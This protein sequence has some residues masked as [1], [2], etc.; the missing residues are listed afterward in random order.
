MGDVS[1]TLSRK[2]R[3]EI[4]KFPNKHPKQTVARLIKR[5]NLARRLEYRFTGDNSSSKNYEIYEKNAVI[6]NRT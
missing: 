6:T 2:I 5:T 1:A 4:K 3:Q